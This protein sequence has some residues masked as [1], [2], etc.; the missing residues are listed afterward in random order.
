[1]PSRRKRCCCLQVQ[2]DAPFAPVHA[3]AVA[4]LVVGM[5]ERNRRHLQKEELSAG[6]QQR[7]M[8]SREEA[9]RRSKGSSHPKKRVV[10]AQSAGVTASVARCVSRL[11]NFHVRK[12]IQRHCVDQLLVQIADRVVSQDH[13][14]S[15][16]WHG[17]EQTMTVVWKDTARPHDGPL[18]PVP[19][20]RDAVADAGEADDC[21]APDV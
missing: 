13:D 21:R 3:A 11:V 19:V 5:G 4:E 2:E 20:Y 8:I 18:A 1:M 6:E 7:S 16:W 14:A 17:R 10:R 15:S 12:G 9:Q